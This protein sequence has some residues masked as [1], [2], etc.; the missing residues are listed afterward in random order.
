MYK[1]V[2][3]SSSG[4]GL[5]FST[6]WS[7]VWLLAATLFLGKLFI[8]IYICHC[9]RE[10]LGI[11]DN[12]STTSEQVA[13]VWACVAWRRYWLGEEMYEYEYVRLQTKRWTKEDLER[14]W[15]MARKLNKE[16][17]MD[18]NRW[19]KLI[20]DKGCLMIRMGVS[21]WMF[22]LILTHPCSPEQRAVKGLYVYVCH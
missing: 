6:R 18:R 3:T 11:D 9:L 17:A 15:N 16:D 8:L 7:P 12:L 4:Y 19:R 22:L 10:R 20:K 2:K 14:L 13:M 21:G 5:W 1:A